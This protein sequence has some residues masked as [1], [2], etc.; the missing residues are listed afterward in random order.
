MPMDRCR[1]ATPAMA[2]DSE[3]F[4]DPPGLL[5]I[6]PGI[7]RITFERAHGHK[8]KDAKAGEGRERPD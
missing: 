4:E 2:G 3:G 5:E 6:G 1:I 7:F 8:T